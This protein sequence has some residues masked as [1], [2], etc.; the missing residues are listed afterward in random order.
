MMVLSYLVPMDRWGE[1]DT[2]GILQTTEVQH[3]QKNT[4]LA[5]N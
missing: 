1:T 4:Y 3:A 2:A 5:G